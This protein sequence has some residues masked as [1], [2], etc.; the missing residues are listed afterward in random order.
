M[1]TRALELLGDRRYR[2]YM[3]RVSDAGGLPHVLR[4][5]VVAVGVLPYGELPTL[6]SRVRA[7]LFPSIWEEPLPYA[8]V[9]SLLMG[10]LPIASRVGGVPEAVEGSPA[11]GY[12]FEPGDARELAGKMEEVMA[13]ERGDLIEIGH[14]LREHALRRF[15]GNAIKES[16]TKVFLG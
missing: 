1:L 8:V 16:L 3:T 12:L 10:P 5:R 9:E 7:L 14:R 6:H 2:V 11:Q 4:D 15:D 13:L